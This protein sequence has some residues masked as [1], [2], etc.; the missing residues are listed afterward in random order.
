MLICAV[1]PGYP[2]CYTDG[3]MSMM[4]SHF[5]LTGKGLFSCTGQMIIPTFQNL[6]I[7]AFLFCFASLLLSWIYK[8]IKNAC[9]YRIRQC[10][11]LFFFS[12]YFFLR[13]GLLWLASN[14]LQSIRCPSSPDPPASA[15]HVLQLQQISPHPICAASEI[16]P[17]G[18]ASIVSIE[19]RLPS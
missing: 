9:S 6:C 15:F 19:I 1:F 5:I 7:R 13:E 10:F 14:S 8:C 16:K 3:L 18:L 2:V 11:L 17:T 4:S 12:S